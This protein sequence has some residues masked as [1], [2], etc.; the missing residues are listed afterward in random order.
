MKHSSS[1]V[2]STTNTSIKQVIL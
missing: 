2:S 1:F